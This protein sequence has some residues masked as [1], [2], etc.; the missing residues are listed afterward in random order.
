VGGPRARLSR[1]LSDADAIRLF[2]E[3]HI[4]QVRRRKNGEILLVKHS[5]WGWMTPQRY[6][7]FQEIH[8]I[9]P[10]IVQGGYRAKS[11]LWGMSFSATVLGTTVSL[12]V[13]LILPLI[14][15][16]ALSDA[17]QSGNVPN[18][19]YWGY[20]LAG[21]FGDILAIKSV[22]DAIA[23]GIIKAI[24]GGDLSLQPPNAPVYCA[25]LQSLFNQHVANDAL[26]LA[27]QVWDK[28]QANGCA[29]TTT[30]KR[31]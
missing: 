2:A 24:F 23:P 31:P 5:S 8:R 25:N 6:H 21:P 28:A 9:L 12:P 13:G 19:L 7:L 15:T 18:A 27:R 20:A 22:V 4:V 26:S 1:R 30:V 3:H 29:W 14:E 17:I 16:V 10:E 11:L